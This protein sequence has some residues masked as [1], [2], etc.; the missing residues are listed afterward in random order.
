MKGRAASKSTEGA[1][2][3]PQ[4]PHRPALEATGTGWICFSAQDWWYHNRAHSDFQLMRRVAQRRPVL[5][6]NSIGMRMPVPGR[7]TQV[8]RRIVRKARSMLRF[9]SQPLAETPG[10]HVLTPVILPFYGSSTA[11]AANAWLIRKQVR[12]A[13]QRVGIDPSDAVVFVTIPTAWDV[14]RPLPRRSLLANRSD[15]HSA[16][17]ETDQAVIREL[18]NEL[19]VHSDVVLYTSHSLMRTEQSLSEDRA[20]F[21]DHGVDF[22]RFAVERGAP[23]GDMANIPHPIVGFFGGIDDYVVNL[24]LLRRV[25][26]ELPEC[27][28]VLIGD[29]TCPIDDLLSLPN[30]HWLGFRPY[31]EIP[32]YGAEFDVALMPWL[33]N[34]WIEHS[35]PIKLKEYLALGLP[36][37]STDF[38]EVHY[39]SDAI[40]IASDDEH[41]VRLVAEALDGK[42]L[43]T[44]QTRRA[45]VART[46]WDRQAD[47]LVTL[48]E[49]VVP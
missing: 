29:A 30:V 19:L 42:A 24:D 33:R 11:R 28:L 14:V 1:T 18:E 12:L 22:D 17:E 23:P 36:V 44:E 8:A 2:S 13:A 45:R 3:M 9:L 26:E 21:F 5:F 40:A 4:Q 37:V 6:I 47:E 35:N 31:E 38:P 32:S 25:A 15:L 49:G 10:F 16:F 39:Y 7:T 43:G 46:T 41:F 20:V 34:E 48:G 27:S